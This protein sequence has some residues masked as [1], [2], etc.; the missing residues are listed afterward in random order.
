MVPEGG[1][2]ETTPFA[3]GVLEGG[4]FHF[5][6]GAQAVLWRVFSREVCK[7]HWPDLREL[8]LCAEAVETEGGQL[9]SPARTGMALSRW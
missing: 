6:W 8:G 5:L 3:P 4:C 2:S 9:P 1:Y 7:S